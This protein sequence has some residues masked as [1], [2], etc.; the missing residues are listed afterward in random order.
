MSIMGI[1]VGMVASTTN[2]ARQTAYRATATQEVRELGNSLRAY[3]LSYQ[4]WK[5]A[6]AVGQWLDATV[7]NL[8]FLRG[9][10][11][12]VNPGGLVFMELDD[13][14]FQE[15][16]GGTL[17]FVDPWG[18]PYQFYMEEKSQTT[19]LAFTSVVSFPMRNRR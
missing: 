9:Q 13:K 7:P 14:K 4:T 19:T 8:E 11:S 16:D 15:S 6:P 10:K 17:A 2:A 1:L 3:W 12:K 5:Y 18:T